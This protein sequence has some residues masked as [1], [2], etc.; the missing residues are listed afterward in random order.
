MLSI[1]MKL[2]RTRQAYFE[3]SQSWYNFLKKLNKIAQ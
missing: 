3:K 2:Y 1:L